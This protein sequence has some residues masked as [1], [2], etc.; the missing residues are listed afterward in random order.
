MTD[1]LVLTGI[2]ATCL[3]LALATVMM[4]ASLRLR[5]RTDEGRVLVVYG[6]SVA[7]LVVGFVLATTLHLAVSM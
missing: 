2:G 6:T 5:G 7:V 1:D 3:V 4:G